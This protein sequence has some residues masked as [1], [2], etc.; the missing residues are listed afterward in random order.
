MTSRASGDRFTLQVKLDQDG[1]TRLLLFCPPPSPRHVADTAYLLQP[2]LFCVNFLN[3]VT[4]SYNNHFNGQFLYQTRFN[5]Q[6]VYKMPWMTTPWSSTP[7][8]H[9]PTF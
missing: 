6:S 9:L 2:L 3:F 7:H 4:C 1:R 8:L 5:F